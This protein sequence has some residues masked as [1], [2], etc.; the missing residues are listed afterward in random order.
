MSKPSVAL[1]GM[2]ADPSKAVFVGRI[3]VQQDAQETDAI[4]SN[5]KLIAK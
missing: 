4:Q 1:K 5:G 3:L 2:L